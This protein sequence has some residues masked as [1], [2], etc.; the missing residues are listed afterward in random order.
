MLPIALAIVTYG[1]SSVTFLARASPEDFRMGLSKWLTHFP[2][3][4]DGFSRD[5][6]RKALT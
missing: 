4:Q 1:D 6:S 2:N 5:L 3:F